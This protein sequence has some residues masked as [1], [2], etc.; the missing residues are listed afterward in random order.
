MILKKTILITTLLFLSISGTI[1]Q[2]SMPKDTIRL[3]EIDVWAKKNIKNTGITKTVIDTIVL[4]ESVTNSLSELLSQNTTIFIK[5]YGRGSLATASFRGTAPSHTQVTWNG[6]KI[7]SPMLGMV[8]FSL[9]PSYFIDDISLW[10]GASSVNM[11]D[12]ALGGGITLSNKPSKDNTNLHLIQSIGNY[13]TYDSYIRLNYGNDKL[14]FSTRLYNAMSD[15]DF[16][17]TNYSKLIEPDFIYGVH[18]IDT[19]KNGNYRNIH[20]LQ[21]I[22]YKAPKNNYFSFVCWLYNSDRGLPKL[23]VHLNNNPKLNI[24]KQVDNNIRAVASWRKVSDKLK[25]LSR[26]GYAYNELIYTLKND[27]DNGIYTAIN[28]ESK[29]SNVYSEL[30][31][32]YYLS[33]DFLLTVKLNYNF[34][35]VDSFEKTKHIG[36]RRYRNELSSFFAARYKAFGR[37]GLAYN[38]R[39]T[40]SNDN[41]TPFI[42]VFLADLLIWKK[43]NLYLKSS[44]VRNYHIPT[45]NDLYFLPGGNPDLKVEDGHTYDLGMEFQSGYKNSMVKA[46]ATCYWSDIENWITW[47]PNPRGGYSD[48]INIKKVK[49][50]GIELK[51]TI[52]KKIKS[53]LIYINGNFAKN[54][55]LN[56]GDRNSWGDES[57]GKQLVY[58]PKY[59]SGLLT[60]IEWKNYY[61]TYKYNYY[62]ERYTTSSN[63]LRR[64]DKLPSYYMSDFSV[65]KNI[66]NQHG[67]LDLKLSVNNIFNE[68]YESVLR[69]PMIGRNFTLIVSYKI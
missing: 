56:Y 68:E 30:N 40:F 3:N 6:M 65:G 60:K 47:I 63:E 50:K 32:D 9:I 15:N 49:T 1:A 66:K 24:N 43:Y 48:A 54:I 58:I 53:T 42:H 46:E 33:N 55:S 34:Y 8:D 39:R 41:I 52:N 10:H 36:Y 14:K 35:Y 57:Y 62:S 67:T 69:R 28:S 59:S 18:P 21:E 31:T 61:F 37:L 19:N 29:I 27:T 4:R 7:N 20:L 11:S 17:Y 51:L 64:R 25:I 2:L 12:G 16:T 44:V 38:V 22:Y 23:G 26:I 13:Q 45:L 5:H